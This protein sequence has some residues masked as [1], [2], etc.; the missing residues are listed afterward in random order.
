MKGKT[1]SLAR[2]KG[3]DPRHKW[4]LWTVVGGVVSS[5][6]TEEAGELQA[7][8]AAETVRKAS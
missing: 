7:R 3:W 1:K 2:Q 6:G 5:I 8:H 4:R